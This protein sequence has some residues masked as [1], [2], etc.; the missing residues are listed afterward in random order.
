MSQLEADR[1]LGEERPKRRLR[2]VVMLALIAAA[3]V[4]PRV[5][6]IRGVETAAIIEFADMAD[7][8]YF[9]DLVAKER[10]LSPAQ[11]RDP[12]LLAFPETRP[13]QIAIQWPRGLYQLAGLWAPIFGA[14]SI[15]TTQLTNL[16][17]TLILLGGVAGLGHGLGGL[18]VGLWAALLTALNPALFAGSWYFSLDYP[19]LA[20]VILALY[21][22]Y[23]SGGYA[24]WLPTLAFA[25]ISA[26]GCYIKPTFVIYLAGPALVGLVFGLVREERRLHLLARCLVGGLLSLGLVLLLL[27]PDW[28]TLAEEMNV[29]FLGHKLPGSTTNPWTG[30]WLLTN[31]RFAVVSYPWPLLYLAAPG[32]VWLHLRRQHT[33]GRWLLI[34]F[35]WFSYLFLTILSTKMER[36]AQSAYPVFCL[37]TAWSAAK[38]PPS[39]WRLPALGAV[40]LAFAA[41]LGV[42]QTHPTPWLPSSMGAVS[43]Q[44]AYNT[45]RYEF[46]M[47]GASRLDRLRRYRWDSECDFQ[48]VVAVAKGIIRRNAPPGRPLGAVHLKGRR[49]PPGGEPEASMAFRRM[50]PTL[51]MATPRRYF[52]V[53]GLHG[54]DHLPPPMQHVPALLVLHGSEVKPE[55]LYPEQLRLVERRKVDF[56]C[57]GRKH[58]MTLSMT[59]PIQQIG[60]Q[61][62]PPPGQIPGR[63]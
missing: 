39:R 27:R 37:L 9:L 50:I 1:N 29:H 61:S 24:R 8:L 10:S 60:A 54:M 35:L 28:Q 55:K 31:F 22:L 62:L 59:L 45:F 13:Q 63:L 17:F 23:L 49:P 38:W 14:G 3:V 20:M 16:L 6:T 40:A 33:P 48:Q 58:S 19:L 2:L 47:P 56:T 7:H 12:F 18:R 30:E 51:T 44:S 53:G 36:Y 21:L 57:R 43:P 42:T 26:L 25:L 32:L 34:S 41:M 4:L 52:L 11:Q 15:W 46:L 5:L